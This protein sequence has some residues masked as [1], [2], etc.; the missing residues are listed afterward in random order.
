MSQNN[1]EGWL[2]WAWT[3]K[4]LLKNDYEWIYVDEFTESD[5]NYKPYGWSL[6]GKKSLCF[7]MLEDFK[8]MFIVVLSSKVDYSILGTAG[9]GNLVFSHTF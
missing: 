5:R 8:M 4:Y 2:R 3:I 6:K 7:I 9:T 1:K